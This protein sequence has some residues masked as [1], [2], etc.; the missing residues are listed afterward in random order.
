MKI[1]KFIVLL[2]YFAINGVSYGQIENALGVIT[3]PVIKVGFEKYDLFDSTRMYDEKPRHLQLLMWY[4]ADIDTSSQSITL[5]YYAE[6][7]ASEINVSDTLKNAKEK[8]V[9]EYV[10][11]NSKL[12]VVSFKF[13]KGLADNTLSR[14]N[15]RIKKHKHPVIY[16]VQGRSGS[17]VDNFAMYEF[18][19]SNGYIVLTTPAYGNTTR[20]M[21]FDS[22]EFETQ[23]LDQEMV[24]DFANDNLNIDAKRQAYIGYSYGSITSVFSAMKNPNIKAVVSLDGSIGYK[25]RIPEV[26][27]FHL[28]DSTSFKIPLLHLN[29]PKNSK[30][31]DLSLISELNAPVKIVISFPTFSHVDFTSIGLLRAF[32]GVARSEPDDD[33]KSEQIYFYKCVLN[34]INTVF[35][36]DNIPATKYRRKLMAK[37]F[38]ESIIYREIK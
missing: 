16:F 28:Y 35:S 15:A 12:G 17:P 4:P 21:T 38:P 18:L 36:G 10:S 25:D 5:K 32:A 19:A 2:I 6:L 31:N 23:L 33:F 20:Y 8:A 11:Y 14:R 37:D 27:K 22:T 29:T 3:E 26:K 1:K 30:R 9:N 34:F 24:Y 7:K 13:K